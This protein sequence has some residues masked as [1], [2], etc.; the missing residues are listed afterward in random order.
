ML[1][2]LTERSSSAAGMSAYLARTDAMNSSSMRLMISMWRGRSSSTKLSGHFSS[3]SGMTVWFVYATVFFVTAH[4]SSQL[5]P[6]SSIKMRMSSGA[7]SVGC[8]SFI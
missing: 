5:K 3:A 7:A 1:M 6:S 4:A 2:T 8:V